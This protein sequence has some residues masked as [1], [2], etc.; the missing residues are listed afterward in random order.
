MFFTMYLGIY[1]DDDTTSE[2]TIHMNDLNPE[3]GGFIKLAF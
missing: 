3:F 1:F 2:L